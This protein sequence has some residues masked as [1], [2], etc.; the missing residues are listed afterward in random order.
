MEAYHSPNNMNLK[1][2]LAQSMLHQESRL[3]KLTGLNSPRNH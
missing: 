3:P 2:T 1:P